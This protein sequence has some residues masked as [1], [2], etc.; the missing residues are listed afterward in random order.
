MRSSATSVLP[1]AAATIAWAL[2]FPA[3]LA[4]GDEDDMSM[5]N[6]M[7]MAT[8]QSLPGLEEPLPSYIH[9]PEHRGS[10]LMHIALMTLAWV[11]VLPL[12]KMSR[13]KICAK[14]KRSHR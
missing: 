8:N 3:V 13:N 11:F 7:P 5:A 12:G 10:L 9:H 6:A 1:V 4:H 14:E 2:L